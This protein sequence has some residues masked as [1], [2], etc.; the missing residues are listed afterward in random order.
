MRAIVQR[1]HSASVTCDGVFKDEIKQGYVVFIGFKVG[2][3][4]QNIEKHL[5]KLVS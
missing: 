5:A 1:V 2:D 3:D 4:K